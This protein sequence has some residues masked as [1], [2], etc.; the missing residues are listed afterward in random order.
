MKKSLLLAVAIAVAS[1]ASAFGNTSTKFISCEKF[2]VEPL[3]QSTEKAAQTR[4]AGSVDFTYAEEP[5][6]AYSLGNNVSP[7]TR[8]FLMIEMTADEIKA[9]AGNKVSGF[10]IY[11]PTDYNGKTNSIT[12]GRFFYTTDLSAEEYTQDF[13]ISTSPMSLNQVSL[14]TPYTI[15]GE[16]KNLYFGY[17]FIIPSKND[18]YYI[19]VDAKPNNYPG[20]LIFGVSAADKFPTNFDNSAAADIGALCMSVKIEGDDLPENMASIS[21]VDVPLYLP[22]DGAGEDVDFVVKNLCLNEI[23]S[24]EVTASVTG[25]PDVV[26]TYDFSP[27][28]YGKSKELTVNGIK[29]KEAAFVD[30]SLQVTKVNGVDFKGSKVTSNVPAYSDGYV[31]K[32]VAEDA[33]GTWCGWCPG[34]IEALEYLKTAYPDKAIAIGVHNDDKMAINSYQA[35]IQAYVSGFPNIMYNRYVSQT[36]TDN[37]DVVCDYI[38]QVIKFFDFPS[39][40]NVELTG[41]T[42]IDNK[43]AEV[44]AKA[45][46]SLKTDIPHYLSFVVVEDGVGPYQQTNYFCNKQYGLKM[47]GW[48]SKKSSV[49]TLFN[50]VARYYKEFPGIKNSLPSVIEAGVANEYSIS[51][52]LSNVKNDNYR[53]IAFITNGESGRIVNACQIEMA[54]AE[55]SVDAIDGSNDAPVEYFNLNGMKVSEPSNGLFIRRQ[56][57]KTEKVIIR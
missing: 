49:A 10:S 50:D 40:A 31:Q 53:V 26:K 48:E 29:A 1:V 18:M 3:S 24:L 7:G 27:I 52:P 23:T 34:G 57:A 38:D 17:S 8:F 19:V 5:V 9:Y 4:A 13:E 51:L 43:A 11:S 35:Y 41:N 25:M 39:Y 14:D 54:K 28:A 55:S 16:E 20:S 21:T 37:Y 30:F 2:K 44:T 56:G 33:T 22:L 15:T 12:E 32:I 45:T 36:P 46:F 42:S 47:N 6:T